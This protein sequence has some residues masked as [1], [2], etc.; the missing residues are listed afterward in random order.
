MRQILYPEFQRTA[1][2][3]VSAAFTV[4]AWARAAGVSLLVLFHPG[5]STGQKEKAPSGPSPS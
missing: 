1:L 3:S 5:T 2:T 4:A